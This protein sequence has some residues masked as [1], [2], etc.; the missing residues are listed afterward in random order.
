MS[1]LNKLITNMEMERSTKFL[2]IDY[3]DEKKN[4]CRNKI[5]IKKRYRNYSKISYTFSY[6][7][8]ISVCKKN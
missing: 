4:Y 3:N 1:K 7:L 8:H 2:L 5:K 6:I